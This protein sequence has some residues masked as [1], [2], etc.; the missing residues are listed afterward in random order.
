[1]E[2]KTP[3]TVA[4]FDKYLRRWII[5]LEKWICH[6]AGMQENEPYDC[7][8]I[9]YEASLIARRLGLGHLAE[10][11]REVLS[12][13]DALSSLG[14]MLAGCQQQPEILPDDELTPQE[15]A[16]LLNV[17]LS[18]IYRMVDG[19]QIAHKRYGSGRG[20]IRVRRKDLL[21]HQKRG[22]AG[23]KNQITL[24]QLLQA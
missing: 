15:A 9:V 19:G 18:T 4:E 13:H 6:P 10:S 1:M 21:A 22:S 8:A 2:T 14:R 20:T 7:A 11:K 5:N 23:H 24:E 17:S 12:R 3:K 16:E